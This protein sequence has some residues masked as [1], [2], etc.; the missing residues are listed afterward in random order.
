MTYLVTNKNYN[1]AYGSNNKVAAIK[2][3]RA[4]T[5]IGLKEAKDAVE[6]AME[7][8]T[9][10]INTSFNPRD[11][12]FTGTL[13]DL[14]VIGFDLS[15]KTI[16]SDIILTSVKQAAIMATKDENIELARLLL[17]V[18]TD[19]E[20][21]CEDRRQASLDADERNRERKHRQDMRNAEREKLQADALLMHE[22]ATREAAMT[23][24]MRRDS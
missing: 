2:A 5:G 1:A 14:A 10:E 24:K 17:N 8:Q 3:V 13:S 20:Q 18:I 22:Q 19:Y 6:D 4:T 16:K 12:A 23:A 21:I 7:G 15:D 11:P 9:V